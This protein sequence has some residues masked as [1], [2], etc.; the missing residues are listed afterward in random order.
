MF[1]RFKNLIFTETG[2]D[3]SI[4]FAG[5]AVNIIVGGLFFIIIPRILGPQS[6][7]ILSTVIVTGLFAANTANFAIDSGLLKFA[8]KGEPNF[9]RYLTLAIKSYLL[10]GAIT[11]LI[12]VAMAPHIARFLKIENH[13]NL[14]QIAFISVILLLLTNF[15]VASL[16]AKKEFLKASCV[17]I[18]SNIARIFLVVMGILFYELDLT[19]VAVI[20]FFIPITSIITGHFFLKF[21]FENNTKEEFIKF[22]KFNFWIALAFIIASVPLDTYFLIKIAGPVAVGIYAAPYKLLTAIHQL[23]GNFSRVLATRY[24]TFDTSEKV[25][26]F[27]KKAA[28]YVILFSAVSLLSMLV[29]P[30]LINNFLGINY[31]SSIIIFRIL[32]GGFIFFFAST[33]PLSIILYYFGQSQVTFNITLMRVL[34]TTALLLIL[35]QKYQAAGAAFA[36]LI[37]EAV[38]FFGTSAY[39]AYKLK[40][41]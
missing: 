1:A 31:Q 2:K 20:F 23:S 18:V 6:Y 24:S 25:I 11:S 19:G 5:T 28:V 41:I 34:V 22:H 16:Q 8:K 32:T 33:I 14:L 21:H 26:I 10:F 40:K 9:D 15:Y 38:I 29:A 3:T 37:T 39:C 30:T 36:F 7:G 4:V 35:V 17:N 27:S 13:Q 12:G